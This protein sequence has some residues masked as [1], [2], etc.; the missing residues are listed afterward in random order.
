MFK[1]FTWKKGIQN[2]D[3]LVGRDYGVIAQEVEK[4]FPEVVATREDGTKSVSYIKLIPLLIESI[5]ELKKEIDSL[6]SK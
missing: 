4:E 5:K 3:I 1:L 2:S 6:K